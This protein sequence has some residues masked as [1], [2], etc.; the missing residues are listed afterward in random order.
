MTIYIPN[1]EEELEYIEPE[2][3]YAEPWNLEGTVK[4]EDWEFYDL[5]YNL[6]ENYYAITNI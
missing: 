3:F 1:F 2:R 5:I 4:D 6:E